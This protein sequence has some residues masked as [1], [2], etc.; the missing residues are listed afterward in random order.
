M[1]GTGLEIIATGQDTASLRRVRWPFITTYTMAYLGMWMALLSPILVG[2]T[3]RT[4]HIDAQHATANLSLIHGLG[5]LVALIANPVFGH[6]SD[7]TRS[8]LGMRRP[9]LIGGAIGGMIGLTIVA[10]APTTMQ[11]L[12]GWCLTQMAFNAEAAAL[13]ALLPDQVPQR[14][15][16][17]VSGITSISLPAGMVLGTYL[18]QTLTMS[19]LASFLVPALIA[20][21]SACLLAWQMPDRRRLPVT[22][23]RRKS[24]QLLHLFWLNPRRFPDFGWT[25]CSRFLMFSGVAVLMAYQGL[26][27]IQQLGYSSAALPRLI[28]LATLVHAVSATIFGAAGGWLSD[29]RKRCKTFIAAAALIYALALLVIAFADAFQ[30]FLLG[31][32]L[33]GAGHGLYVAVNRA[34][35]AN[36]L[37]ERERHAARNLGIFNIADTLPQSM[38]PALASAILLLTSGNYTLLFTVAAAATILSAMAIGRVAGVR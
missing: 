29:L 9:W 23:P 12:L 16:G 4:Q 17:T 5:A 37:P 13:A 15:R 33:A 24:A 31:M 2:L 11:L 10:Q 1:A 18:V 14:Q 35:A 7:L 21:A 3:E 27:L 22:S 26:Y 34:L 8:R 38:M 36:V 32:A 20:V 25:W 19:V 6:L 28:F 30:G